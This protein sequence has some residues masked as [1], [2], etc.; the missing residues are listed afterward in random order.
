[1]KMERFGIFKKSCNSEEVVNTKTW[2]DIATG[3]RSCV[4]PELPSLVWLFY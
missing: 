3:N 2:Q 4:W 1:M